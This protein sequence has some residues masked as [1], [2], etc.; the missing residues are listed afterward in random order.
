MCAAQ[1]RE[2]REAHLL[3][4]C[5]G[6]RGADAGPQPI[7]ATLADARR[8]L[9]DLVPGDERRGGAAV[10]LHAALLA[11]G[12]ARVAKVV[13]QVPDGARVARARA[14]PLGGM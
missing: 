5:D 3:A 12:S 2:G 7:L 6:V 8:A 4:L 14:E 13:G 11:R 1:R 9:A 10:Q